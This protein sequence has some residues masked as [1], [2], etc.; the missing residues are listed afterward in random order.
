[1]LL[2][3]RKCHRLYGRVLPLRA[4]A[5]SARRL[6]LPVRLPSSIAT[7]LRVL[8]PL[9]V[10]VAKAHD[11]HCH[12]GRSGAASTRDSR[13]LYW[14]A[15]TVCGRAHGRR[16]CTATACAWMSLCSG[17]DAAGLLFAHSRCVQL[18]L[19]AAAAAAV[20]PNDATQQLPTMNKRSKEIVALD[21][22]D[23]K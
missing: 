11:N 19:V 20:V 18:L 14:R 23:I 1:M 7:A 6:P 4:G 12:C 2:P 5:A 21:N 16:L 13:C 22:D 9:P 17:A 10:I 3:L 8:P 15:I